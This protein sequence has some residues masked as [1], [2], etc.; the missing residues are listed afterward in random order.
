MLKIDCT[1]NPF[2]IDSLD[3]VLSI[4]SNSQLDSQ[5]GRLCMCLVVCVMQYDA[6][7]CI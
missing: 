7:N 5:S 3:C 2:V 1:P 6:E 4:L